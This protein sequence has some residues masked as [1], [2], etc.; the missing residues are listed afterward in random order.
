MKAWRVEQGEDDACISVIP[1]AIDVSLYRPEPR[2]NWR[3]G[4]PRRR[5]EPFVVAFLGRLSEEKAPDS[6]IE[7]AARFKDRPEFDFLLG[8]TGNMEAQL[9][10]LCDRR[11]LRERVH[12]LGFISTRDYLPC[13]DLVVVCSRIDGCPNILMES[14]AMGV[15]VLASRVGGIPEMTPDGLGCRLFEPQ[16]I[17]GFCNAIER[18]ALDESEYER[19]CGAA[20]HRAETHFSLSHTGERYAGL[21][22]ELIRKRAPLS[23][24]VRVDDL[25]QTTGIKLR[26]GTKT[27]V[28]PL[29]AWMRFAR[30][31][32][33][34]KHAM[35][36]LR[37]AL[38]YRKLKRTEGSSTDLGRYFDADY[39]GRKYPEAAALNI[40]P[41]WYYLVFG[42]WKGHR[43]SLLLDRK[44]VV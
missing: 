38:L 25:V 18:L 35:G 5:G 33:S 39:Y 41:L 34:P 40:P 26:D 21:F 10:D 42:F 8:G 22:T 15:P 31:F 4:S 2:L 1:N 27:V 19:L 13:C 6:F 17:D 29:F 28:L 12:F 23:C 14:M 44:S 20:R 32:F 16:D 11:G 37:T 9:R 36:N 7:I 43:P 24:P 3:T 30:T